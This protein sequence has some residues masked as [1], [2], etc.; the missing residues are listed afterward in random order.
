MKLSLIAALAACYFVANVVNASPFPEKYEG[1]LNRQESNT[2]IVD[3]KLFRSA[4][5][6]VIYDQNNRII[7]PSQWPKDAIKVKYQLDLYG[8]LWRV[9]V[10][11]QQSE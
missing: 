10:I 9:W 6:L 3:K 7:T 2:W 1:M 11:T 4:P 5:G 8:Q